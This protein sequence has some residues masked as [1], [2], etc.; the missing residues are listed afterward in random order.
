MLLRK[1]GHPARSAVCLEEVVRNCKP[2]QLAEYRTALR[3]SYIQSDQAQPYLELANKEL[4]ELRAASAQDSSRSAKL[5]L[6]LLNISQGLISLQQLDEA[7]QLLDELIGRFESRSEGDAWMVWSA[8]S[9]L[10]KLAIERGQFEE[11]KTLLEKCLAKLQ[12]IEQPK[13]PIVQS[14]FATIDRLIIVSD[15]LQDEESVARWQKERASASE[16]QKEKK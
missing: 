7:E 9:L 5:E 16:S 3:V 15:K 14:R 4:D 12:S 8:K 11:A 2:A 10:G 6:Q 13:K 1:A